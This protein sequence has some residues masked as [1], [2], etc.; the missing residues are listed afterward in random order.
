MRRYE[1]VLSFVVG[2]VVGSMF[3]CQQT[4]GAEN[5]IAPPVPAV[6]A[7]AVAS[8]TLHESHSNECRGGD[9]WEF[10]EYVPSTFEKKWSDNINMWKADICKG[11]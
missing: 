4:L 3:M 9:V 1:V 8:A 6:A 7:K 5:G 10:V 2:A 11:E